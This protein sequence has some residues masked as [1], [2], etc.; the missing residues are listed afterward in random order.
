MNGSKQTTYLAVGMTTLG[1]VLM[2]LAWNGA[3]GVD[4]PEQQLPYLLSGSAP[5]LGLVGAGLVLALVSELRRNTVRIVEELR[6]LGDG[7]VDAG[8]ATAPTLA[9]V[10]DGDHVLATST[11]YHRPDCHV[12]AGRSDVT[13][14]SADDAE[15]RG[16]TACRVCEPDAA[17]A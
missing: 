5:G 1:F 11:S 15:G 16:L 17:A 13:A 7:A 3:A 4:N 2:F 8:P 14:M 9:S 12:A 6:R 10:P